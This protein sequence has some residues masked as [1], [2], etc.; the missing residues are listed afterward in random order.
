MSDD[1]R[2]CARCAHPL[3]LRTIE[4][5]DRHA[6]D[7]CDYVAWLDPKVAACA[8]PVLD[9]RLVMERRAI[10]P[11]HGL[12]TFP[13][14]YVDRG[15]TLEEAAAREVLEEVGLEVRIGPLVG[16]YSSRDSIV[17][18]VVYRA[19]VLGGALCGTHESLE[20]A[21]LAPEEI[22]WDALAFDATRRALKDFLYGAV[23]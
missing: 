2:Y 5:R 20:V 13:G 14:G 7:A 8:I 6:C 1:P 9:G 10:H 12:W 21:A 15:E 3:T 23:S 17:I 19:E 16:V 22:P 18:V 11:G 4:G